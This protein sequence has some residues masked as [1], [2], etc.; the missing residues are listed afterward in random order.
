LKKVLCRGSVPPQSET[1]NKKDCRNCP[2]HERYFSEGIL[3]VQNEEEITENQIDSAMEN[4]L[5]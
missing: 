1:L 5:H 3:V 2:N 4:L